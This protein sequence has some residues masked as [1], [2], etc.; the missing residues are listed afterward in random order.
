MRREEL[1]HFIKSIEKAARARVVVDLS[2]KVSS[3]SADM[4]ARM[5][6]GKKYMDEKF[7]ERGFK[8]VIQEGMHIAAVFNIADYIPQVA[9]LDLQGLT[10][11]MKVVSKVF[12]EFLEKILDE[13]IQSGAERQ[14]KAFV[15]I[16]L[17]IMGSEESEY[18][19]D[20]SNIKATILDILVASLDTAATAIEWALS[21]LLI[22]PRVMKRSKMN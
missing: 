7:D 2:A 11:R 8:A 18:L 21:E 13:H 12:D 22:H 9:A 1:G 20:R 14:T 10:R 17:A 5:V 19:I 4:T 6:L 3:L 16:M 15:D